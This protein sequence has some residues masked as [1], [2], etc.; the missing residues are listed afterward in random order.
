MF[1]VQV[2]VPALDVD[3]EAKICNETIIEFWQMKCTLKNVDVVL[4]QLLNME[5]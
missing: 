1:V 3:G 2:L 4:F 5:F